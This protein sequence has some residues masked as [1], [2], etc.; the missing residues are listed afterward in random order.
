MPD[1]QMTDPGT[2]A[3]G[4]ARRAVERYVRENIGMFVHA[5]RQW[6]GSEEGVPVDKTSQLA[7]AIIEAML[8][9]REVGR[10][11]GDH[12]ARRAVLADDGLSASGWPDRHEMVRALLRAVGEFDGARPESPQQV[13]NSALAIASS[14]RA[15]GEKLEAALRGSRTAIGNALEW[16][17]GHA[18]PNVT[19]A[20]IERGLYDAQDATAAVLDGGDGWG[21]ADVPAGGAG[22][23]RD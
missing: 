20:S 21:G 1:G 9:A 18:A 11:H 7:E 14:G 6:T 4:E 19:E 2:D 10:W 12:D 23:H 13:W 3:V 5:T 8:W 16:F 17:D 22:G 15:R